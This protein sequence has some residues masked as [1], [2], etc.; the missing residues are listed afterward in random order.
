MKLAQLDLRIGRFCLVKERPGVISEVSVWL[1]IHGDYVYGPYEK[2]SHVVK[3]L[4]WSWKSDRNL[5]G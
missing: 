5:V 2:L 1:V 4:I 3:D